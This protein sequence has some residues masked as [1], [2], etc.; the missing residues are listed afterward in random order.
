MSQ[1]GLAGSSRLLMSNQLSLRPEF[2]DRFSIWT[3]VNPPRSFSPSK[4]IWILPRASCSSGG[5]FPTGSH[6]PR[7]RLRIGQTESR[8][9]TSLIRV[10]GPPFLRP[11]V[12]RQSSWK[13]LWVLPGRQDPIYGQPKIIVKPTCIVFFERQRCAC[14]YF[15]ALARLVRAFS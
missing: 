10:D 5:R 14:N 2:M 8:L 1:G 9:R 13:A 6:S 12:C 3:N 7:F 11:S 4:T 15:A